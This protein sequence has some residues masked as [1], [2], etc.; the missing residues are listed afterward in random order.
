M[1]INGDFRGEGD[2]LV[3]MSIHTNSPFWKSEGS[4]PPAARFC[5]VGRATVQTQST[6]TERILAPASAALPLL[7]AHVAPAAPHQCL[8]EKVRKD[9]FCRTND[10]P[11]TTWILCSN[12][13]AV[14]PMSS[15][16]GD[17][18]AGRGRRWRG[19]RI[20]LFS[21]RTIARCYVGLWQELYSALWQNLDHID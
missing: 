9:H 14:A 13:K 10:C 11:T 15:T 19:W 8:H 5:T 2:A 4:I 7:W 16:T 3:T 20:V 12:Y 6:S 17:G 1:H 21:T 18:P